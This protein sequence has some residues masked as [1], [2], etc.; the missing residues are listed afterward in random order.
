M[1][2]IKF[3]CSNGYCGCDEEIYEEVEENT[4]VDE[5]AQEILTNCYSFYEPDG[6]FLT[7]SSGWND[8]DYDEYEE[9]CDEY[10]QNLSIDWEEVT[11]EE[12]EENA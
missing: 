8:Y 12:Y 4:D 2:Y 5:L 11:K 9:D 7:H 1:K 3:T 10:E 6:R